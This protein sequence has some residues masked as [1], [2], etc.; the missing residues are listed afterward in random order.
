MTYKKYR[1]KIYF[2]KKTRWL[3]YSLSLFITLF[4]FLSQDYFNIKKVELNFQFQEEKNYKEFIK[5]S[6]ENKNFFYFWFKKRSD[7]IKKFKNLFPE[8]KNQFFK[9]KKFGFYDIE[10]SFEFEVRKPYLIY[11]NKK[12]YFF[13]KEGV[14]F[15]EAEKALAR[16][17]IEFSEENKEYK[18]KGKIKKDIIYDLAYIIK[19]LNLEALDIRK[20]LKLKS[21]DYK[22]YIGENSSYILLSKEYLKQGLLNL[23]IFL[24]KKL[25]EDKNYLKK[26]EYIDARYKTKIFE[27]LR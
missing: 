3:L 10:L 23:K 5:K 24:E 18:F 6:A 1:P 14:L 27:K 8:T 2:F 9:I 16:G 20:I 22:I 17:Y 7:V 13:D 11:C 26:I 19:I 25:K 15:K 21:S 4:L 12:C